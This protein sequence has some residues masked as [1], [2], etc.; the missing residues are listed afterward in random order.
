MTAS[1]VVQNAAAA[2]FELVVDGQT[3]H[4]DYQIARDRLRLIHIEVPPEIQGHHHAEELARAALAYARRQQ[5]RVV[6]ICPYMRTFLSHHPEYSA[7]V[8][9]HW[10]PKLE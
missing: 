1:Q 7:L 6:P 4:L 5:L 3:A 2:R 10:V 8:D 9:E